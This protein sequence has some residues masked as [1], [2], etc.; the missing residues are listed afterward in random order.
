M[1]ATA[2]AAVQA[3]VAELVDDSDA[4]LTVPS[5]PDWR[6]ADVVAHLAG[7]CQDWVDGR[8]DGYGSEAWTATQVARFADR[9]TREV[10]GSWAA[11]LTS[12]GSLDADPVMGPPAR[13]AF[14]DAVV[15]EAD[16][17]GALGAGRVPPDA[18]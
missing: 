6:V 18:V 2:Y 3:R 11:S 5:C 14:G 15:H 13:W 8:L 10:L 17:R 1:D 12:F 7:L 9:P 16:L 4:D